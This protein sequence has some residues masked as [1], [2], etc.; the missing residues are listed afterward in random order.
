MT[1]PAGP[2]L[3]LFALSALCLTAQAQNVYRCGESYSNSPC[4]GATVVPTDD[5]RSAAQ[6]AQTDA[7]T[8]RDARLAQV[9]ENE[10]LKA[11]GKPASAVIFE[12]PQAHAP[13]PVDKPLAKPKG[14]GKPEFF[15]AVAPRKPG[16][17]PPK[18]KK[19]KQAPAA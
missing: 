2:A 6:K 14:K 3:L 17:A 5:P 11:E 19:K 4:A 7:A 13:R 1:K 15:T 9:L 18:K 16:D 10:R 8:K 12:Q